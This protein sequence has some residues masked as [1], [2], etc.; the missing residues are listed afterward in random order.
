MIYLVKID[1]GWSQYIPYGLFF[2]GSR[3]TENNIP[4]KIFHHASPGGEKTF[5]KKVIAS[6]KKDKPLAIGCSVTT[7][8]STYYS[9]LFSKLVKAKLNIPII[10]GGVHPTIVPEQCIQEDYIDIVCRGEGEEVFIEVIM[11]LEEKKD[12]S[13][14]DGI[15]YKEPSGKK[16]ISTV[17]RHASFGTIHL[18]LERFDFSSYVEQVSGHRKLSYITSR[19]CPYNCAFCCNQA[20][21]NKKYR[22]YPTEKVLSDIEY[23]KEKYK[24]TAI[25]FCDDNLF[26]HRDRAFDIVN[27]IECDWFG[28]TRVTYINDEFCKRIKDNGR[29]YRLLIGGESG[30]D[31]TL[32][33]IEKGQTVNEM[34]KA[35]YLLKKYDIYAIWCFIVGMP[36]ETLEDIQETFD[37]VIEMERLYERPCGKIGTFMPYPGTPLFE[38]AMKMGWK[39]PCSTEEWG[40]IESFGLLIGSPIKGYGKMQRTWTDYDFIIREHERYL[41]ARKF[42]PDYK[43]SSAES[44]EIKGIKYKVMNYLKRWIA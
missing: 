16:N 27:K 25:Q 9:A 19:G 24:V 14:I 35:L 33:R 4:Y 23:L 22:T 40:T 32:R 17:I 26:V 5:F 42:L 12:F 28:A 39:I 2:I 18:D 15:A 29:C 3:L 21:D 10:W 1:S 41:K 44:N 8:R 11:A 34:K 36:G 6:A 30:S 37:F 13:K 7:G 38:C 20:L 43:K 31:S